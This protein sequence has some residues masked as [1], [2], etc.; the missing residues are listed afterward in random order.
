MEADVRKRFLTSIPLCNRTRLSIVR[1]QNVGKQ[2]RN[3]KSAVRQSCMQF[4]FYPQR[5]SLGE[6]E[7][8]RESNTDSPQSFCVAPQFPTF[9]TGKTRPFCSMSTMFWMFSLSVMFIYYNREINTNVIL[10]EGER[11]LGEIS[12]IYVC[13]WTGPLGSVPICC[14]GFNFPAMPGNVRGRMASEQ[15]NRLICS[16]LILDVM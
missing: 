10:T 9:D 15:V 12:V 6:E 2:I 13:V 11:T 7:G 8:L 5:L 3:R 1:T 16:Q 4:S 14:C